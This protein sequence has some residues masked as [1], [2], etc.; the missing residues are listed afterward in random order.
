MVVR[1]KTHSALATSKDLLE[2]NVV[3]DSPFMGVRC[4]TLPETTADECTNAIKIL[5]PWG[6]EELVET[7][8]V[9]AA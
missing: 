7:V 2:T 3:L 1:G 4:L 6:P 8:G 9:A 5:E